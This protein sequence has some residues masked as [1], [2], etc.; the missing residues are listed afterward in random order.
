MQEGE[1]GELVLTPLNLR[2]TPLLRY[3]TGDLVKIK[4]TACPCGRTHPLIDIIGRK[5]E[6]LM[7]DGLNLY[8][9]RFDQALQKF[10]PVVLNYHVI[11][12]NIGEVVRLRIMCE[13]DPNIDKDKMKSKI[14]YA[15]KHV[16][17]D[18]LEILEKSSIEVDLEILEPFALSLNTKGKVKKFINKRGDTK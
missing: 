15:L 18:F 7:I 2:G 16:S 10:T 12:E 5:D 14:F 4:K 11:C 9:Y 1:I 17:I 8:P 3:R 6:T 13:V